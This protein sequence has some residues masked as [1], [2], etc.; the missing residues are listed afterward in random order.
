MLRKHN[1]RT[2]DYLHSDRVVRRKRRQF[3]FKS[4]LLLLVLA[5]LFA[6]AFFVSRLEAFSVK[7]IT[8]DGNK[9]VSSSEVISIADEY[10]SST[11]LY[12]FPERNILLYPT[13]EVEAKL[14][15]KYPHFSHVK[16]ERTGLTSIR[17]GVIERQPSALWCDNSSGCFIVDD[18]GFIYAP[19]ENASTTDLII[20]RGESVGTG[21]PIGTVINSS[22]TYSDIATLL[23]G[24]KEKG[25][26][27]K[28]VEIRNKHEFSVKVSPGGNVIFSDIRPLGDSLDNLSTALQSSAFKA[29]ST[30]MD[31]EY[32][33]TRF[34]NKIFFKM[35]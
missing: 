32:I 2:R 30:S 34:G 6:G 18:Q 15:S 23:Q 26:T 35:K 4:L 16:V 19:A 22:S 12:I 17:I 11:W 10:A 1:H 14:R 25:L 20:F 5:V 31:F 33:D 9:E 24:M 29:T 7:E 3:T 13:D 28:E 21:T 8:V 27:P